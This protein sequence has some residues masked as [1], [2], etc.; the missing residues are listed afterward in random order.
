MENGGSPTPF[1]RVAVGINDMTF[2]KTTCSARLRS[3]CCKLCILAAGQCLPNGQLQPPEVRACP[4]PPVSHKFRVSK[5]ESQLWKPHPA[6]TP[7][8][9]SGEPLPNITS[10]LRLSAAPQCPASSMTL[11]VLWVP[12]LLPSP[13]SSLGSTP[14]LRH[15]AG[16]EVGA[17]QAAWA[18][19]GV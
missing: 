14:A 12:S 17:A 1:H 16:T 13:P 2:G 8:R 6:P 18:R 3:G 9:E 4:S 15:R 5:P 7:I 11:R 19:S 10:L